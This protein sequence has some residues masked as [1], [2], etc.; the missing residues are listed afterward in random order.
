MKTM[1]LNMSN[2]NLTVV[3]NTL[4]IIRPNGLGFAKFRIVS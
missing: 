2:L 4:C 1:N 3:N